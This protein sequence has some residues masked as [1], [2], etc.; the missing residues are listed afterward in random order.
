MQSSFLN[1]GVVLTL[2][3]MAGACSIG[4]APDATAAVGM[5]AM[6]TCSLKFVS[7]LSQGTAYDLLAKPAVRSLARNNAPTVTVVDT[8]NEK[9]VTATLVYS[10]TTYTSTAVYRDDLGCTPLVDHTPASLRQATQGF[11]PPTRVELDEEAPWPWGHGP[12]ETDLIPASTLAQIETAVRTNQFETTQALRTLAVAIALDGRLIYERYASDYAQDPVVGP[13][14]AAYLGQD[15][16]DEHTPLIGFST[17]KS[18]L[19]LAYGVYVGE[20]GLDIT[21]AF[22]STVYPAARPLTYKNL[23]QMSSGLVWREEPGLDLPYLRAR[24]SLSPMLFEH[25]DQVTYLAGL[26]QDFTPDAKFEYN[27]G[28]SVLLMRALQNELLADEGLTH[29]PLASLQVGSDFFQ[30]RL[31]APARVTSASMAPDEA[32]TYGAGS[33]L[34]MTA[35]DWLRLG[36]L[37][38]DRGYVDGEEVV[39]EAWIND[40]MLEASSAN[41]NYG[42]HIWLNS[43]KTMDASKAPCADVLVEPE[44]TEPGKKPWDVA[45]FN[46]LAGQRVIIVPSR[47]LVFARFGISLDGDA[48]AAETYTALCETLK[49]LEEI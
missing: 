36:Q 29:T 47:S 37:V 14:V 9:S 15:T 27:T 17:T 38:L 44:D 23:L 10:G 45:Y 42:G 6:A 11:V 41:A 5:A 1:R 16:V 48:G 39:P 20:S 18:V 35:R 12:A 24:S 49:A 19:A 28:N 26:G 31:F 33:F 2:A 21:G 22:P 13:K 8:P 30:E 7:G 25:G 46:G 4:P 34:M 43:L 32:G 40:V 3:T